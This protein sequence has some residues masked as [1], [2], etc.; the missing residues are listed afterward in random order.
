MCCGRSRTASSATAR[1]ATRQAEQLAEFGSA[2]E[3]TLMVPA[4][5][6]RSIERRGHRRDRPAA[7]VASAGPERPSAER[8]TGP[9][10]PSAER[11]TGP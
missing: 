4:L 9:E 10:R 8:S 7:L 1:S 6:D 11:S 3:L 2:S 5:E